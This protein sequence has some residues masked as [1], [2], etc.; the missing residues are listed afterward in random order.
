LTKTGSLIDEGSAGVI[1]V[2]TENGEEI[3]PVR[4][5][6]WGGRPGF[7]PT[8]FSNLA[9]AYRLHQAEFVEPGTVYMIVY[10]DG[11]LFFQSAES[12]C[13]GNGALT[14]YDRNP[15][16]NLYSVAL[17]IDGCNDSFRHLN[18]NFEGLSSLESADPWA[19]DFSVL[20]LWVST[21]RGVT[22]PAAITFWGVAQAEPGPWDY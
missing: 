20:G 16:A 5:G 12:G 7:D 2:A 10:S 4:I 1:R 19:Y 8:W 18:A 21:P 3:W 14:P 15:H 22:R 11:R 13:I 9:G 6:Y 17:T